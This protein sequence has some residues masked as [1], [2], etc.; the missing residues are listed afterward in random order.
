MNRL[1]P[2]LVNAGI[3]PQAEMGSVLGGWFRNESVNQESSGSGGGDDLGY[4][5][6]TVLLEEAV[7]FMAPAKGKVLID[8]TLG[9]G[10]H[11]EKMLESGAVVYGVDRDPQA[12]EYAGKRLARFGDNFRPVKGNYTDSLQHMQ[13]R[14]VAGVDGVLVDLGVSSWQFDEAERG[15]SFSKDGPLDMRMG[16]EGVTAGDIVN[17]WDEADLARIFWEYGEERSSRKIAKRI[18]EHRNAAPYLTTTQLAESIEKWCPRMGKRI[19]PAT[20]VFQAL[21]IEVNDELGSLRGLLDSAAELLNPGGRLCVISF[22]SLED[23][24]VKRFL[25]AT[26][27]KEIDRKEWPAPKPNPEYYFNIV[28]RKPVTASGDEVGR[29]AR[30]RSAIMRVAERVDNKFIE[31]EDL[32]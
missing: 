31:G 6:E 15:F 12:L 26:S 32:K 24:M 1:N 25:K 7:H 4:Y 14:G 5:H 22:H 29:N 21:R 8:G 19:H 13:E 17:N 27:A 23:R 30:S 2:A 18:C 16:D 11:T 3:S 20:K 10:G 9:G 28:S